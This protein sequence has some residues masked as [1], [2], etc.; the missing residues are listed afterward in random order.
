VR[1]T[2]NI[3]HIN[4]NCVRSNSSLMEPSSLDPAGSSLHTTPDILKLPPRICLR[5]YVRTTTNRGIIRGNDSPRETRNCTRARAWPLRIAGVL[6][7][8]LTGVE[9]LVAVYLNCFL[10]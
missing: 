10:Y 2:K 7:A 9:H 5:T 1:E 4:A 8:L 3:P 6:S